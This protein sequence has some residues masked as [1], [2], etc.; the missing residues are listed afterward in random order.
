MAEGI[1]VELLGRRLR[2][3]RQKR[4]MTLGQVAEATRISIPT[5]SRIERGA[6][7][8]I[9]SATLLTL[10]EWLGTSVEKLI[11]K[12]QPV[13]RGGKA[14]QDLPAIVDLHLRADKKLDRET[15]LALSRMFRLAYEEFSKRVRKG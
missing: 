1:D 13:V 6:S 8:E 3:M 12:P 4:G 10:A 9:E 11:Q 14:V 5:L 2:Q 7:K 15:A